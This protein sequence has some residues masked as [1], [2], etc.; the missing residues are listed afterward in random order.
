MERLIAREMAIRWSGLERELENLRSVGLFKLAVLF[1]AV[2]SII[3]QFWYFWNGTEHL[4]IES[5]VVRFL[6]DLLGSI[7]VLGTLQIFIQS[8]RYWQGFKNGVD[9]HHEKRISTISKTA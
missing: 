9:S 8:H 7:V 5:S 2:S 6:G 3:H 1:A 4:F